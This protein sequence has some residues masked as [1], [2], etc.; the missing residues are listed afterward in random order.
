MCKPQHCA[1]HE[2]ESPAAYPTVGW[3]VPPRLEAE[4]GRKMR[5]AFLTSHPIQYHSGWFRAMARD[6]LFDLEVLYC[7]SP[8]PAEQADAGFGTP[9]SWDIPLLGGYDHRF[10]KNV[11]THPSIGH[12]RGLDTPEL[13]R[14]IVPGRYD[15]V[16]VNGWHYKSAWQAI[17]ACWRAKVPVLV[18]SDSHLRTA[19][20]PIKRL[21]KAAPYRWFVRRLDA[22]LPA[23]QWSAD[24]FLHYGARPDRVF[25]VPHSVDPSFLTD[26]DRL[27][28]RRAEF[29]RQWGMTPEQT[30]F[31]FAGKFIE[32]KRPF[33]FVHAIQQAYSRDPRVAGLM[34]GDGPLRQW[35]ERLVIEK[36][37]PIR[38]AGFL[39]Q[40]QIVPA[41]VAADALVL[42]SDGGETW[43][44]VVNEAMTCGKP[45]LVSD[46]VGCGP[47]LVV[48]GK[49][50]LVFPLGD[51]DALSRH[52]IDSVRRPEQLVTMGEH[53]RMRMTGYSVQA[54]VESLT[55]AV[56]GVLSR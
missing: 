12:F 46:H 8:A 30:V 50:G 40:S 47:D 35:C 52:I 6:S 41:Y 3:D 22:C 39:N 2:F 18:R 37:L 1:G 45:C 55:K 16:V 27:E 29:R 7:H 19:R 23:G 31:L 32:K 25:I 38:F 56:T 26:A 10:L 53:A 15:A 21:L 28:P 48:S 49:T 9:F 20:S 51:I 14:L 4:V 34:V 44:M 17:R 33:D 42:P 43:G 5:L 13:R 24:Y 36:D 54:A 11:S